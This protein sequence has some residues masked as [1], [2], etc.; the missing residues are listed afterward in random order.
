MSTQQLFIT[1][2]NGDI[3][4]AIVKKFIEARYEIFSPSSKEL[5]LTD[6]KEID[7]YFNE[8]KIDVDVIIHCAGFNN[9]KLFEEVD[10]D[11]LDNT[12]AVNTI[13]FYKILQYLI[14]NMKKKKE[15]HVLAISSLYGFI[16]R[17]K[18]LS[19]SL[20]KHAL[21]GLVKTLA[22]ELGEY[23]IKV[24]ALSPGFIDTQMT[25]KNNSEEGIKSFEERIPLGRLCAPYEIANLAYFLCSNENT[26]LTGQN[27]I[28][29]GGYSIG[30]FQK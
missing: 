29:D 13:S 23:N 12:L 16:S 1:G 21:H 25:R 8:N 18:R 22:I 24:N 30:G 17:K 26:Y 10:Y 28:I 5:N 11:D 4:K 27:I 7:S 9:P 20:S 6:R 3:G 19:Y 2:G 14:P 15:G